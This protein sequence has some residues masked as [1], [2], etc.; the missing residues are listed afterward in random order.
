MG[1]MTLLRGSGGDHLL[2]LDLNGLNLTK[3]C[4][5]SSCLHAQ[6]ADLAYHTHVS[7]GGIDVAER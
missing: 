6:A 1:R 4:G 5:L 3:A 7:V 2:S